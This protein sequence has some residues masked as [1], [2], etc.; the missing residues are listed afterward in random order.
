MVSLLTLGIAH[1]SMALPSLNR[2]LFN[3]SLII[4]TG[5]HSSFLIPQSAKPTIPHSTFVIPHFYIQLAVPSAVS[6]AVSAAIAIRSTASQN[7]FF[8]IRLNNVDC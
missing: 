8:F 2:S 3:Y 7:P 4:A 5:D 1:A 6:A